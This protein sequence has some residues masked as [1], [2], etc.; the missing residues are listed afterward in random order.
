MRGASAEGSISICL[1]LGALCLAGAGFGRRQCNTRRL[2]AAPEVLMEEKF[3]VMSDVWSLG[4]LMYEVFS[5]AKLPYHA[6]TKVTDV[7]TF[8]REGGHCE[9]SVFFFIFLNVF[10]KICVILRM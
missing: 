3:S 2:M 1:S 10:Y 6:I 8:I 5:F 9:R 4:V 7:A